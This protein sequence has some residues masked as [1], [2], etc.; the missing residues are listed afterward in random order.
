MTAAAYGPEPSFPSDHALNQSEYTSAL[1]WYAATLDREESKSYV[2]EFLRQQRRAD[3]YKKLQK[4]SSAYVTP[5]FGAIAKML[6]N[7]V[8]IPATGAVWLNRKLQELFDNPMNKKIE[9]IKKQEVNIQDRVEAKARQVAGEIDNLFED[10]VWFDS[11]KLEANAI[12]S[13]LHSKDVSGVVAQKV[14]VLFGPHLDELKSIKKDPQ[15][16]EAYAKYTKADIKRFITFYQDVVDT[17]KNFTENAKKIKVRKPRA[18]KAVPSEKK[19]AKFKYLNFL[20][21]FQLASVNPAKVIG[22]DQV[23]IYNTKYRD[24]TMLNAKD[25]GGFDVKGMTFL[26]VDLNTSVMRKI[27]PKKIKDV[28]K[29]IASASGRRVCKNVFNTLKRDKKPRTRSSSETIILKVY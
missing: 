19:L 28:V 24:L 26:N 10:Y 4:V 17:C 25:R 3:D 8:R 2:A 6:M 18:K 22:A 13:V 27:P 29:S 12:Y 5:T 20:K 14:A 23:W 21:E 11:K 7:N 16:K 9:P 15:L 1:N